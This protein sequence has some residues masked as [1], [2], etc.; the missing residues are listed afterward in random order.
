MA[1]YVVVDVDVK[2]PVEYEE[3]ARQAGP[4]VAQY[5]GTYVVRGGKHETLEGDWT[6]GRFVVLE[7]PSVEQ[8]KAWWNSEEYRG[9]K[10]LRHQHAE[11]KMIVVEGA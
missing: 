2:N 1:A 11:S 4:T 7:F 9:P 6:P 10:A 5:G 8:A 3:Y